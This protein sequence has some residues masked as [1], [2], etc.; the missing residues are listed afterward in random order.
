MA[1]DVNTVNVDDLLV[2]RPGGIVRIEGDPGASIMPIQTPDV[3]QTVMASL[4]YMN[5]VK[6]GRTGVTKYSAGLDGNTLNKTASG[7]AQIQAAANQR[8]ELIAR[9]LAGG[10]RDLFMIVH[11]LASKHSTKPVQIK[12]NGKWIAIDPRSWAKRTD[13]SISVGLG[14]GTPEQQLQKLL[15]LAPVLQQGQAMGLT[16]PDEAYAFASEMFKAAGYKSPD[17]FMHPPK[18]D[19]QGNPITPP[20]N[21]DPLVQAAEVKA[22]SDAQKFQAQAQGEIQKFQAEQQASQQQMAMEAQAKEREQQNALL[23]QQSNDQRQAALDERKIALQEQAMMLEDQREREKMSLEYA[24]K[25]E[26][27][28][29]E[30]QSKAMLATP[31]MPMDGG[32]IEQ[33]ASLMEA[34]QQIMAHLQA[35]KEIVRDPRTGRAIGVRSVLN[36]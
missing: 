3:G 30:Q 4:D 5:S 28:M 1:V 26:L 10:F 16:G 35:P 19:E 11:T 14:T 34:M 33:I 25:R 9:T 2:S 17:K 13:F 7:V 24:W 8:I 12:L 31:T 6:E 21:K 22:Q 15:G 29:M 27:A 36:S 23:L 32:N 18:K 20:P